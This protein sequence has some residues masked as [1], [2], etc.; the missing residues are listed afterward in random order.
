[1]KLEERAEM[2]KLEELRK[3]IEAS[4]LT[5]KIKEEKAAEILAKRREAAGK[6]E[7]LKKQTEETIPKFLADVEAKEKKYKEAKGTMDLAL[8]EFREAK[9]ELTSESW[10]FDNAI[11]SQE[12]VLY[13][14][15]DPI[16]DETITFFR[17][18]HAALCRKTPDSQTRKTGSN[19]FAMVKEFI[20]FSNVGSIKS[21]L[22]YCQTAIRELENMKLT[23][24]LNLARIETLK[25]KIPNSDEMEEIIGE[26]PFP[27]VNVDPSLLR[28]SDSEDAW[29]MRKLNDDFKRLMRK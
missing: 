8:A 2:E 9:A 13:E 29:S 6:I 16:I 3:T 26:K 7:S 24:A 20:T 14:T 27:R 18:K 23:P 22:A 17:D 15:A 21:A 28:S 11:N 10:Q 25:K 19:V 5:Q 12:A 4:P 1:M